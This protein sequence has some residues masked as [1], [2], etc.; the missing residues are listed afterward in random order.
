MV[1]VNWVHWMSTLPADRKPTSL[2]V[3]QAR[4]AERERNGAEVLS[5]RQYEGH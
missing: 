5:T 2:N 3:I 4:E 1:V